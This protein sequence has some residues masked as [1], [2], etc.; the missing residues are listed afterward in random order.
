S[1]LAAIGD[2]AAG[3]A[4][5]GK[6][7][8]ST[9]VAAL[10][11]SDKTAPAQT[12]KLASAA[13][14]ALPGQIPGAQKLAGAANAA[15]PKP[16]MPS[17]NAQ[18]AALATPGA[19]AT[20]IMQVPGLTNSMQQMADAQAKAANAS[21]IPAAAAQ[22]AMATSDPN[23]GMPLDHSKGP[24][25][26]V[27][28][29]AM[30]ANAMQNRALALAMASGV[31]TMQLEHSIRNSRFATGTASPSTPAAASA[32]AAAQTAAA[33]AA[34]ASSQTA[35]RSLAGAHLLFSGEHLPTKGLAQYRKAAGLVPT[36]DAAMNAVN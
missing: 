36:Q 10:F 31:N 12:T 13:P 17:A 8:S 2:E 4:T 29:S 32:P 16:I 35:P 20:P 18:L 3:E 19:A 14:V 34:Q 9:V 23:M 28:D 15:I 26:G 33:T 11:G 22:A 5:N 30:M 7:L 25:S 1:A 27:M 21:P 6:S 24:Y